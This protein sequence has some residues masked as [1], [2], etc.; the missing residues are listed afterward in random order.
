MIAGRARRE[1]GPEG[2]RG[3]PAAPRAG[4]R[5]TGAGDEKLWAEYL[6]LSRCGNAISPIILATRPRQLN[7]RRRR[8]GSSMATGSRADDN[9]AEE[10]RSHGCLSAPV[11]VESRRPAVEKRNCMHEKKK[12]IYVAKHGMSLRTKLNIDA[13][14]AAAYCEN[15]DDFVLA[16]DDSNAN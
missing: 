9:D 4:A 3:R 15:A 12:K 1:A 14:Y 5:Q 2:S 10:S 7:R 13:A 6:S 8:A 16:H 11:A